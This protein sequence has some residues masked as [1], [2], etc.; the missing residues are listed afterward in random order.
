[1]YR[2]C[3]SGMSVFPILFCLSYRIVNLKKRR[4]HLLIKCF[5]SPIQCKLPSVSVKQ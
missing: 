5:S 2:Y 1:M 4:L 3:N